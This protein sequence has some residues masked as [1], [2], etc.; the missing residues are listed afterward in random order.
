[1][2][3]Y[4]LKIRPLGSW[5]T[6]WQA[7]TLFGQ[8]CGLADS[9]WG[10]WFLRERILEPALGGSP[11]FVLSDAFPGDLLPI[12]LVLRLRD[13]GEEERKAVKK[14][15][16][17]TRESF[18]RVQRGEPVEARELL[19]DSAFRTERR[20]RNQIGRL[21]DTTGEN[22]LFSE[23]ESVLN[24][25]WEPL[26][27]APYLSVYM[28]VTEGFEGV[29]VALFEGLGACG[30]GADASVGKGAFEVLGGLEPMSALEDAAS[31]A[32]GFAVLSTFQP[33]PSDSTEGYWEA[34]VKYGKL[35]A[36]WGFENENV[37]KHPLVMLRPGACFAGVGERGFAGQVLP[38]ERFL[39]TLQ[40][41]LLQER[42]TE[43]VH[44]GF[45]LTVPCYVEV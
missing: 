22:A 2:N 35:G 29:V 41:E 27:D 17:L 15:R 33:A 11:P 14:T 16:W 43:V 36:Q 28:R 19:P 42:G 21:T 10:E 4:R 13:W 5:I 8:C 44:S 24:T 1:M 38:M 6:P 12:P 18:R 32:N 40:Q 26:K 25:R 45:G 37:F 20:L 9:L 31:V 7:D 30:H 23:I 34:F 3:L 39:T